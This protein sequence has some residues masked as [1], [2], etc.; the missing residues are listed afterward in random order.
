MILKKTIRLILV[1]M[2][3][4]IMSACHIIE[5][6]PAGKTTQIKNSVLIYMAANNSL[7]SYVEPNKEQMFNSTIPGKND[8]SV[9]LIF[10]HIKG[11]EDA[12]SLR[13]YYKDSEGV[14]HGELI[15]SYPEVS[16]SSAD[17]DC[18]KRVLDDADR[19]FPAQHRGLVLWSHASGWVPPGY[20]SKPTDL[21]KQELEL[22]MQLSAADTAPVRDIRSFA[23]DGSTEIDIIELAKAID[24]KYDYICFDSC[25]MG[26]VEVAYQLRN[27]CNYMIASPTEVLAD[28]YPY[29]K[30]M[31]YLLDGTKEN[32][33][34]LS[35]DFFNYYAY[36]S[37]KSYQ[38]VTISLVDC[39]KLET[40]ASV[41]NSI[42]G[43]NQSAMQQVDPYTVQPY[44]RN[45]K[46]WFYDM[47]DYISKFASAAEQAEFKSVL[48]QVMVYRDA[49]PKFLEITINVYSGLSIYVPNYS[50]TNLNSYYRTLDWNKA[51]GLL[52]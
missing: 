13:R 35:K 31:P 25:L 40:L 47:G 42:F 7:S 33:V 52:Q 19:R 2:V 15:A 10:T 1:G 17:A 9:L 41:C 45:K 44:F 27:C 29:D 49:T 14:V 18:L 36:H 26:T 5:V 39:T 3:V 6:N 23:I 24:R 43:N 38:N 34:Q 51:T 20:F 21:S 28:G 46:R 32:L 11:S 37:N 8:D 50:A 16:F 48:E 4:S 22:F 30:I 12:P